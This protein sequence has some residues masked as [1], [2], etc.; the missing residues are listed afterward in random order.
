[1]VQIAQLSRTTLTFDQ[2]PLEDG[3]EARI[4]NGFG[5]FTWLQAGVYNPN[6]AIAGYAATSGQNLLFI[7]EAGGQDIP[8]YDDAAPGSPL[9]LIRDQA[10]ELESVR[11]SSAF[12]TAQTIVIRAYADAAGQVLIGQKTVVVGLGEQ[13]LVSFT[14][15]LDFGTFAGALRVEFNGNDGN[16]A[17]LDYFGIDDL[18]YSLTANTVLDFDAIDLGNGSEAVLLDYD[19][20]SFSQ[21]GVYDSD[22]SIPGYANTSGDNLAFIAEANGS[23]IS[24]YEGQAAGAPVVITN[25][26]AFDF[27]GGSFSSAFRDDLDIVI[28]G[29]AD[30]A[31]TQ[32][33]GE[34]T[35]SVDR[36]TAQD[37]TFLQGELVGLRRLEFDSNDDNPL[38]NDYFGFDDLAFFVANPPTTLPDDSLL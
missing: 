4:P 18:T 27:L 28:R 13:A 32:L 20:F 15:G 26:V 25:D 12:Q 8:G 30:E 10:F 21:T 24:G 33:V 3:A 1:M 23:E 6:G 35:I 22:G 38:T 17:T 29:Y 14:D 11:L 34:F 2:I 37:F 19:G 5:G 36:F 31:G 7:A 16:A 9:T